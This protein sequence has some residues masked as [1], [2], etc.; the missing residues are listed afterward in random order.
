MQSLRLKTM[1]TRSFQLKDSHPN[2]AL[3]VVKKNHFTNLETVMYWSAWSNLDL[4]I[5]RVSLITAQHRASRWEKILNRQSGQKPDVVSR[6]GD[7]AGKSS[8]HASKWY[9]A[10]WWFLEHRY[11]GQCGCTY[12]NARVA[13]YVK[14]IDYK[15]EDF[16]PQLTCLPKEK[17]R[18]QNGRTALRIMFMS[19]TIVNPNHTHEHV[20][21][22]SAAGPLARRQQLACDRDKRKTILSST[23]RPSSCYKPLD[24]DWNPRSV[25]NVSWDPLRWTWIRRHVSY[26]HTWQCALLLERTHAYVAL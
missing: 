26:N 6:H 3:S 9:L 2:K 10:W 12:S 20:R 25:L 7:T 11:A 17:A 13:C 18:H 22:K 19:W 14:C 5:T 8:R 1:F 4:H 15:R 24:H 23:A 16:A 21:T